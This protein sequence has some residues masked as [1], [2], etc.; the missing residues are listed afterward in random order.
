MSDGAPRSIALVAARNET[1]AFQVI[2]D[3]DDQGIEGVT[4]AL[5]GL[6]GPNGTT[7]RYM[8]PDAD[9]SITRD[10]PI[11]LYS[12]HYMHVTEESHADWVWTPGSPA[13]PRETTGWKPVQLVPENATAGRGSR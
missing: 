4:V 9:P 7:I 12:V 13:A 3:A 5:Q 6:T 10:R 2:V 11:R 1:I 8:K